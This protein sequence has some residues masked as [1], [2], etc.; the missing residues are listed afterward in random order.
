MGILLPE[1]GS[2]LRLGIDIR[3]SIGWN[4]RWNES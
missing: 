2:G 1:K 4:G 3:V